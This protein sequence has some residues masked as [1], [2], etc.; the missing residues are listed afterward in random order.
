[1]RDLTT[2][3]ENS[4]NGPGTEPRYF[5]KIQLDQEYN[6]ST[7]DEGVLNGE[8]Y[9]T[10]HVRPGKLTNGEFE[11][12]V[13]N[14]GYKHTQNAL[15]GAYLRSTVKVWWAYGPDPRAH[16][17][18][19]GYWQEGYTEGPETDTPTAILMFD[20]VISGTPDVDQWLT[21]LC[22]RETPKTW[23]S[24][25][26]RPPFANFAPSAG[27]TLRFDNQTLRIQGR[28]RNG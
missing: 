27:Y 12:E 14:E 13:W 16:Y 23:P 8:T 19:P 17:V 25:R 11:L 22:Q 1:M 2:T 6:F 3:Q 21:V 28:N 18:T 24:R 20:G 7:R 26:I 10:G 9:I 15:S 4:V 5:I